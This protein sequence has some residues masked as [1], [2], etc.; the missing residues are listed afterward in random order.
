VLVA[1]PALQKQTVVGIARRDQRHYHGP[2]RLRILGQKEAGSRRL[3]PL[4]MAVV[5]ADLQNGIDVVLEHGVVHR[6]GAISRPP[7]PK[8]RA[9]SAQQDRAQKTQD[10]LKTHTS[11]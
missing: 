8:I 11:P 10:H 3:F 9:G 2:I 1:E 6:H 5:T 4:R 7:T